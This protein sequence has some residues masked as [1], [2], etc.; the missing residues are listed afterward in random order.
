V[1]LASLKVLHAGL[2]EDKY[3]APARSSS[4]GRRRL[5]GKKASRLLPV[6]GDREARNSLICQ[7]CGA[8]NE[9]ERRVLPKCPGQAGVVSGTTE[10]YEHDVRDDSV[11]R[12]TS[13]LLSGSPFSKRVVKGAPR[14]CGCSSYR[15]TC[16]E[17]N[18]LAESRLR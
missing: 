3:T 7:V 4:N 11:F 6:L 1:S 9:L 10:H 2:G 13:S 8:T 17:R 5:D 18:G 12:S 15:Q 16:R 14:R